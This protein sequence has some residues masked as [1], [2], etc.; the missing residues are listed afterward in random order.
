ML[1]NFKYGKNLTEILYGPYEE[2]DYFCYSNYD[3]IVK[4]F[5]DILVE[6]HDSDYQ[7]DSRYLIQ[8]SG[9]IGFLVIGWGSCSGCDALQA[10]SND[11]DL[12]ELVDSLWNQVKW[13]DTIEQAKA[14]LNDE[15]ERE[16]SYYSHT[17]NWKNFISEV[18]SYQE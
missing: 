10:C 9:K 15:E 7:G 18:N 1:Y 5:G 12:R 14:Y 6:N 13:F 16:G 3:P 11:R 17:T 2:D 4:H 8:A